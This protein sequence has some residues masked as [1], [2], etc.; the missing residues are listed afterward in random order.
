MQRIILFLIFSI[1]SFDVAC[2]CPSLN[3]HTPGGL[4]AGIYCS[5]EEMQGN[6]IR[7]H[8]DDLVLQAHDSFKKMGTKIRLCDVGT[9]YNLESQPIIVNQKNAVRLLKNQHKEEIRTLYKK[10]IK[11]GRAVNSLRGDQE[12]YIK[13]MENFN[14]T[15][16]IF[17]A[18]ADRMGI[19][20]PTDA[21]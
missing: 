11:W 12:A 18:H 19:T 13:G 16:S 3:S 4:S 8:L 5:L 15:R 20:L 14:T 1:C 2:S 21:K 7:G 10:L 17:N 6:S 9:R